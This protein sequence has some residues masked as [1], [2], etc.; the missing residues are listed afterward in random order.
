M[1]G[2]PRECRER[3][4]ECLELARHA[5]TAQHKTLLTEIAQTW[6]NLASGIEHVE[7]RRPSH[8]SSAPFSARAAARLVN[9]KAGGY[10][11]RHGTQETARTERSQASRQ[12]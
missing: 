9:R 11:L 4:V 2:D 1:L 5:K 7:A 10:I 3:A 6:L 8:P 12:A